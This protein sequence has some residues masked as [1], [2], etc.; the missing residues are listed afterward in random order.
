LS[1]ELSFTKY[2][3]NFKQRNYKFFLDLYVKNSC[4]VESN[5]W[6]KTKTGWRDEQRG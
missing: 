6:V 2:V 4:R 5:Q 3:N 1:V